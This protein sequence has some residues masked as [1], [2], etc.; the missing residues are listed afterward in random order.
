MNREE[1]RSQLERAGVHPGNY[2]LDGPATESESYS[3]VA[4]GKAWKVLYKERGEF[5]E[6]QAGLSEIEACQLIYRLFDE[7]HALDSSRQGWLIIQADAFG[8]A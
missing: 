2:S 4:D 7:A 8:P 3:L 1:L 5:S 6:I